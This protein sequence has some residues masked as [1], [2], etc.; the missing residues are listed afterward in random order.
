M[1]DKNELIT[2]QYN[3]N[4]YLSIGSSGGNTILNNFINDTTMD[5]MN[6]KDVIGVYIEH[7]CLPQKLRDKIVHNR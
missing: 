1:K 3:D 7:N 6:W 4:H 2:T 5:G